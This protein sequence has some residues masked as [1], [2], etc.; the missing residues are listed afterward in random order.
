MTR[1]SDHFIELL[2]PVYSN[3]LQYCIALT[4]NTAEAKDL[5]QDSLL[6]AITKFRSLNEESKFRSWFFKIITREYFALYRRSQ[7]VKKYMDT[8]QEERISFPDVFRNEVS[9]PRQIALIHA[10]NTLSEKER[11]AIVLFEVG[12]FSIE[13]IKV[14]QEEKSLSAIKSRLSRTR[15]KLRELLLATNLYNKS[16]HE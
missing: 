2:K 12:E 1:N 16:S 13:E 14:I 10:L 4:K 6:K 15:E 7:S 8:V 9:D 3:A 11:V 5:L